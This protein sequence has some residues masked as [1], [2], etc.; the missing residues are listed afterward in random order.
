[1]NAF[2]V[3]IFPFL[4]F[5][6]SF[7]HSEVYTNGKHDTFHDYRKL[8]RT[9]LASKGVFSHLLFTRKKQNAHVN[10][11]SYTYTSMNIGTRK[12]RLCS[13][14]HA[15]EYT[16]LIHVCMISLRAH[17]FVRARTMKSLLATKTK[18]KKKQQKSNKNINK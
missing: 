3:L 16:H 4:F 15:R 17:L 14:H 7:S 9:I 18:T 2:R 11:K 1:M 5:S 10:K 8:V 6:S 12:L 13:R